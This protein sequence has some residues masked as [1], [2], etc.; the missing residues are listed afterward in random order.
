M[1]LGFT[2]L[3][4]LPA[5]PQ[6]LIGAD[7]QK[8]RLLYLPSIGLALLVGGLVQSSSQGPRVRLA[9]AV[10]ARIIHKFSTAACRIS[11]PDCVTLGRPPRRTARVRLRGPRSQALSERAFPR[12]ATKTYE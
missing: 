12:F 4:A 2:L 9:A 7:L 5:L 1:P 3:T 8:S 11:R 10:L 6:L